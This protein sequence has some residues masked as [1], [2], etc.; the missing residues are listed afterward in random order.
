MAG[1]EDPVLGLVCDYVPCTEHRLLARVCAQAAGFVA[2]RRRDAGRRIGRWCARHQLAAPDHYVWCYTKL[3]KKT[4][5]R[6]Y[7]ARYPRELVGACIQLFSTKLQRPELAAVAPGLSPR[8]RL[9][10]VLRRCAI[11]E[12]RFVGW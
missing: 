2:R 6:S 10:E 4:L 11:S 9:R 5:I 7:L 8:R 1:H 3:T 12:I